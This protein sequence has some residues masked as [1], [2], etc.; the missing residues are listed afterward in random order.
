MPPAMLLQVIP[1]DVRRQL[2]E[3]TITERAITGAAIAAGLDKEEA[4]RRRIQRAGDMELQQAFLAR[5]VNAQ[6]TDEAL[7]ARFDQESAKRRARR[8]CAPATSW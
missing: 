4:V 6:V 2:L 5:E 1:P 8:R 3:R 7:R